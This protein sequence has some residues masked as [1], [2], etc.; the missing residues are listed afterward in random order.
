MLTHRIFIVTLFLASSYVNAGGYYVDFKFE[1]K[2]GEAF[3]L[4]PINMK[5][6]AY[7]PENVRHCRQLRMSLDYSYTSYFK[8]FI[9]A[10]DYPGIFTHNKSVSALGD[11]PLKSNLRFSFIGSEPFKH[12]GCN[13]QSSSLL[14][15]SPNVY[16]PI[17]ES[18][19]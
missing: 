8:S 15:M 13:L 5:Q 16:L 4:T 1:G 19:P 17:M 14:V 12:K 7:M 3:I 2:E 11:S 18:I 6:M 9:G 10:A